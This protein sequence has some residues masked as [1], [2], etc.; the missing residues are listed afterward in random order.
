MFS[1]GMNRRCFFILVGPSKDYSGLTLLSTNL[2]NASFDKLVLDRANFSQSDLTG[3]L[4]VSTQI[5]YGNFSHSLLSL[6]NFLYADLGGSHFSSAKIHRAS[7]QNA[8]MV[9]AKMN[10]T[11]IEATDF[12][13]VRAIDSNFSQAEIFNSTFQ[14]ADISFARM[15]YT[16]IRTTNF[17]RVKARET[18]FV[19]SYMPDCLFQWATLSNASFRHA[20]LLGSNF[21]NAN[22]QDVDFTRALLA[23]VRIT[24]G[25]LETAL[26]IANAT[27]PD[28]K[29][30]KNKNLLKNG[31]AQC[32]DVNGT[33]SDWIITGDVITDGDQINNDCLFL[34]GAADAILQQ[35]LDI[36]RYN[37]LISNGEGQV[38][39][40]MQVQTMDPTNPSVYMILRFFNAGN[41][42]IGGDS[43]FSQ[44]RDDA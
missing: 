29:I 21:E 18:N 16:T 15:D 3:A 31:H 14:N 27:L 6:S 2:I 36:S 1:Y 19:R 25:Q 44:I 8:K 37:R 9:Q 39:I 35:T 33:I 20:V 13:D 17:Y 10:S 41:V 12:Q 4:F 28:G 40:E 23:G 11:N 7:F 26:S 30:G 34:A 43:E 32:V 24:P 5:Y 42:Q 22:V 38:Y